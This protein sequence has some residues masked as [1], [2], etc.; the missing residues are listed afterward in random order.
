[1]VLCWP[2]SRKRSRVY[3]RPAGSRPAVGFIPDQDVRVV[4]QGGGD[5]QAGGHAGREALDRLCR[6][7]QEVH[8]A[9]EGGKARR[10]CSLGS[11]KSCPTR[12][13]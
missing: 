5:T 6:R 13:R 10:R 12:S 7:R 8:G 1:M 3:F 4:H 9:D 11:P 2:S